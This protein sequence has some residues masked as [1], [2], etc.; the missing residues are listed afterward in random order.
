MP[1]AKNN[2]SNPSPGPLAIFFILTDKIWIRD[3][4]TV[5]FVLYHQSNEDNQL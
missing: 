4:G 1:E 2:I 3:V 5:I